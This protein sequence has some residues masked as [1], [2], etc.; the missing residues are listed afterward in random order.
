MVTVISLKVEPPTFPPGGSV[1]RMQGEELGDSDPHLTSPRSC[2]ELLKLR[3][4]CT[5]QPGTLHTASLL[6]SHRCSLGPGPEESVLITGSRD[7]GCYRAEPLKRVLCDPSAL[8]FQCDHV[9]APTGKHPSGR[10]GK[11]APTWAS[12]AHPSISLSVCLSVCLSVQSSQVSQT[13]PFWLPQ[14]KE[15]TVL[16]ALCAQPEP[17]QGQIQDAENLCPVAPP[18]VFGSATYIRS[19]RGF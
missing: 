9:G 11:A 7:L 18:S 4:R 8:G 12:A 6:F 2:R 17:S 19:L 13:C 3:L 15:P 14:G 10:P 16:R 1:D 5:P